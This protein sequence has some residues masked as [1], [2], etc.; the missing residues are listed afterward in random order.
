[1]TAICYR[2]EC[3]TVL[4]RV[5]RDV[6]DEECAVAEKEEC[7]DTT[8][9]VEEEVCDKGEGMQH[10]S[11]SSLESLEPFLQLQRYAARSQISNAKRSKKSSA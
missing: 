2:Q 10:T 11:M 6:D 5:C 1:M 4:E 3:G 9:A 8:E 7:E